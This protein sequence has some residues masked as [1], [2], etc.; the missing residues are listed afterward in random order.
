MTGGVL[1]EIQG[2]EPVFTP[3]RS[4]HRPLLCVEQMYHGT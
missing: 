3:S 1:Q 2:Q 4:I